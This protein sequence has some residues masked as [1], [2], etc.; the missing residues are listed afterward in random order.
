M[1]PSTIDRLNAALED[2][3]SIERELGEGG[4][5]T[6]YLAEDVRHKRK[7]ALKVLKP[8]LAAVVGGERFLAEIETTAQLQHPHILP[9]FDSGE[10]DG[11]LFYVMPYVEGESLRDRLD[12]EHQLPVDEAVRIATQMAEAL[13]YAH[14]QG[15][16]HRDVKPANVLVQE[17]QPVIAD[18]GIALAVGAAGGGRL[19]ETGLSL[20]TPH[21]M[22]PEQATGEDY[23]GPQTDIYAL[24]C[25]LYETLAGQPP[26]TGSTAQAILAR[27]IAGEVVPVTEHRKSVPAHVDAALRC[28]L[29][30]VPADRF[31]DARA[32]ARA[33]HD[34]AFRHGP[35]AAKVPGA[36]AGPWKRLAIALAATAGVLALIVGG[37]LLSRPD[38]PGPGTASTVTSV[39][40]PDS[41]DLGSY[42]ALGPSPQGTRLLVT[43]EDGILVRDLCCSDFT[44]VAPGTNTSNPM[45]SPDGSAVAF[46]NWAE[47]RIE[48]LEFAAP[49]R[50]VVADDLS[51]EFGIDWGPDDRIL[52]AK[53]M[54]DGLWLVPAGGGAPE[55][56]TMP[57]PSRGELGHW[58]PT[59]LPG[60]DK[61]LFTAYRT[62]VDSSTIEVLDLETGER[63]LVLTG[64]L[65]ARY[66]PS[67]HLVY[68]YWETLYAVPFNPAT[69]ETSGDPTPVVTDVY[70]RPGD[71]QAAYDVSDDGVLAYLRATSELGEGRLVWV[72]AE[73]NQAPVNETWARFSEPRLSPDGQ[74]ITY[75]RTSIEGKS[76]VYAWD[77]VRQEETRLTREDRYVF[78]PVWSHDGERVYYVLEDPHYDIYARDANAGSPPYAVV[79]DSTENTPSDVS[80]DGVMALARWANSESDYDIYTLRLDGDEGPQPFRVTEARES[81]PVFSPDGRWI[82]YSSNETG[83]AEIWVEAYPNPARAPR[84]QVSRTGTDQARWGPGGQLF[85]TEGESRLMHATIDPQTGR[86]SLPTEVFTGDYRLDLGFDVSPDGERFLVIEPRSASRVQEVVIV[87]NWIEKLKEMVGEGG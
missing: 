1:S 38:S 62:P 50:R 37:L 15:V 52:Y 48:R 34:P 82:A 40:F 6:V 58:T 85:F 9:L 3:Y 20:G 19:T 68:V 16:I 36:A 61:V 64:G 43:T 53:D 33:L 11:F 35:S 87:T 81:R 29:E 22:S 76:D 41:F 47:L 42:V 79:A 56:L 13:D 17:G 75:L 12:R 21:Y 26:H 23:L 77:T 54:V 55:R 46:F 66:L 28:G 60:G 71:G 18:F 86:A 80:Q 72:D 4:M 2:R 45:L 59:F 73:G 30:K 63:T 74:R 5:A 39:L 51:I 27:I 49:S 57:D 24:A 10:A 78:R 65:N 25:V 70:Y 31:R 7:V 8:E 32:F 84:Q 14:R 69:L 67:G 44:L 83:R